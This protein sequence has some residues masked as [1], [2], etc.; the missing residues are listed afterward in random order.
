MS[1]EEPPGGPAG[2]VG[3]A[4]HDAEIAITTHGVVHVTA[5]DWGSL[6]YG[7][8]WACGRDNLPV[9]ADQVLKAN[10]R[11]ARFHGEGPQGAHVASDFGYRM[12]GLRERAAALR[13]AQPGWIADLVSG[14]VA[15]YNRAVS[16]ADPDALP[17]WCRGAGWIREIDELDFWAHIGDVTLMASGRNLAQLIG[18]AEAPGPDGPVPP[19]PME[20]LGPDAPGASN[21]WAVGGDVTASGGGMVLANPHF[22]WYGEARFWECHLRIPGEYDTYGV[23]LLGTPGV[24]IGFNKDLAWTHTFSRGH[25]FTLAKLEL[26][27]G[28]PTAYRHGDDI[29]RMQPED[30]VVEVADGDG[31]IRTVQR[32]LWRSHMGPMLNMPLL[33][34][35]NELGFTFRDANDD[36]SAVLEQFLRMGRAGS[37]GE[38]RRVFHEVK[39]LPWVNTMAADRHGD[40]WYTDASATP[41]LGEDARTRFRAR[42]E[43]DFVAALLYRNRIA[44]LDGSD[45]GDEWLDLP[46]A[47]SPGLL[48]PDALPEIHSRTIVANANDSHWL[49][50]TEEVLEGYSPMGGLERTPRSLR[51]RQNLRRARAL[52]E[53]G[54]LTIG[55]LL[56]ELWSNASMSAELLADAVV[57]RCAGAGE[58]TV[59]GHTA[60]LDAAARVI[61]GWDRCFDLGSRGAVLWREFMGSLPESAW[62]DAGPL[63][64]QPFDAEH[65]LDTPFGL[66]PAPLQGEDPVRH[67]MG[68]ALRVLDAAGIRPDSPLGE[69]QWADRN[70]RRV[71]VHGGGECEGML[72]VLAPSGALPPASLEPMPETPVRIPGREGTG[73]AE[74][75]YRVTYGTSFVM[76]VEL[77]EDGPRG[78]GLLAYGQSCDPESVHHADGTEAYAAKQTRHLCFTDSQIAADPDL[79]RFRLSSPWVPASSPLA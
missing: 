25:R 54:S 58:V 64:E 66:A 14:Y 41:A 35:S 78:V 30:H 51:T 16:E 71:P 52:I 26:A 40:A 28:E 69:V 3:D 4:V 5:G 20:A 19:S 21:G 22:P 60:D 57:Q 46:G 27:A 32:R 67:A 6:G 44:L 65:P 17:A 36:N 56:G 73:L 33:G 53:R 45:P 70:G 79:E 62:L 2:S 59:E 10:G 48:P 9:I 50:C 55:D 76:A 12:L 47:R 43:D 7:Q 15:G 31:G 74:G 38:M 8:G 77:T 29:R 13:D 61:D 1:I 11:R 18:R 39:G 34:W 49:N 37:V 42:L 63:F 75:G 72:N 68:H 24:Q 23:S